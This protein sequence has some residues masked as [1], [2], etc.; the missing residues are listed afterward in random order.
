[1]HARKQLKNAA[2]LRILA[3]VGALVVFASAS[4]NTPWSSFAI[5][6][7]KPSVSSEVS[8]G[9]TQRSDEILRRDNASPRDNGSHSVEQSAIKNAYGVVPLSFEVNQGQT[10]PSVQFLSRG[11]NSTLF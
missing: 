10:D 8:S 3:I 5:L 6:N 7:S 4:K 11:A 2:V 1:M 9:R